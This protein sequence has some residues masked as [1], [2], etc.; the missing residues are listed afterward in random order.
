MS[1]YVYALDLDARSVTSGQ[2]R[3]TRI[4]LTAGDRAELSIEVTRV[5][6]RFWAVACGAYNRRNHLSIRFMLGGIA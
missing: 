6:A 2:S 5:A 3:L 1:R 4:A